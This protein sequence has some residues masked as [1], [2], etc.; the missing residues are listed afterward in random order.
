MIVYQAH[1]LPAI[2]PK[3][4]VSVNYE[5]EGKYLAIGQDGHHLAL[6]SETDLG[7]CITSGG[8]LCKLNQALYPSDRVDWCI[9]AL[10]KQDQ[11][12]VNEH[13]TYNF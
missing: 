8:G 11:E 5:L 13:C 4:N 3:L 12:T 6:P 9:Y 2:H 1:N 7:M 10:F